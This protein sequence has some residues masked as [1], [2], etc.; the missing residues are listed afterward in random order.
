MKLS[1]TDLLERTSQIKKSNVE[2]NFVTFFWIGGPQLLEQLLSE[3][4]GGFFT[5]HLMKKVPTTLSL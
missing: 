1:V 2:K 5:D 3:S 4:W